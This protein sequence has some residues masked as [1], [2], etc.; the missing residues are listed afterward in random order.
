MKGARPLHSWPLSPRGWVSPSMSLPCMA[1]VVSLCIR[2]L[3]AL[4]LFGS[5]AQTTGKAAYPRPPIPLAPWGRAEQR[6]DRWIRAGTCL[7][8]SRVCA[9]PHLTRAAQGTRRAL[10]W[11]AFC[12]VAKG[13][14]GAKSHKASTPSSSLR[15]GASARTVGSEQVVDTVSAHQ[16][17]AA[18]FCISSRCTC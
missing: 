16:A 11:L 3:P 4:T 15:T 8:R 6:S 1:R 17:A 7:R 9:R 13:A 2:W 12:L 10:T 14:W 5:E 18:A